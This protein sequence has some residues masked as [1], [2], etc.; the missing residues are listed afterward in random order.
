[1]THNLEKQHIEL[2]SHW[3]VKVICE[4]IEKEILLELKQELHVLQGIVNGLKSIYD[5]NYV[6]ADIHPSNVVINIKRELRAYLIDFGKSRPAS[7]RPQE[8]NENMPFI[9]PEVI[10]E[11]RNTKTDEIFTALAC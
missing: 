8:I 3:P 5:L 7:A 10:Q 4:S 1:L 6:H 11:Q 2:F 9:A